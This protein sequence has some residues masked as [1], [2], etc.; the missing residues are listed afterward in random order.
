AAARPDR[1]LAGNSPMPRWQAIF[2]GTS[3]GVPGTLRLLEALHKE[4]GRLPWARLFQPAI[5]LAEGGFAV[6]PRLNQLLGWYGADN[7]GPRARAYFF[8]RVGSPRPI[9]YLLKNPELAATLR[10]IA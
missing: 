2:G 4:H 8:D 7:F 5:R 1:F 6:S 10:I 9:G 3:V